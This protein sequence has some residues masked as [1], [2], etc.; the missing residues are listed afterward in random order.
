MQLSTPLTIR[1]YEN[2]SLLLFFFFFLRGNFPHSSVGKESACN[3]RRPQFNSCVRKIPWRRD[4][5]PTPIFLGFPD[6]SAGK[7]SARNVETWVP[8]LGWED[9]PE[10]GKAIHSSILT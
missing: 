3:G 6:G 1:Y 10:K 4:R 7:E 5:L 8:S 9:P 2:S